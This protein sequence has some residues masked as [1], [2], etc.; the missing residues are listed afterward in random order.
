VVVWRGVRSGTVFFVGHLLL[1]RGP[2][3]EELGRSVSKLGFIARE[4]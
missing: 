2:H 4:R 3:W 1:R